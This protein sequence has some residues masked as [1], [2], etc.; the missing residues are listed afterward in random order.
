MWGGAA[1]S[2]VIASAAAQLF[3]GNEMRIA[4]SFKKPVARPWAIFPILVLV[5]LSGFVGKGHAQ[6]TSIGKP[7]LFGSG[8]ACDASL[9]PWRSVWF[10]HFAGGLAAYRPG[11]P[12][13]SLVWQDQKLCFP[14]RRQCL[15][16][17]RAQH[18][19]FY[20]IHG[21]STCLRIR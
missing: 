17:Q 14:S 2:G 7:W 9:L 11:A 15:S 5:A 19:L 10:G 13:V 18:R 20:Q 3:Q 1:L 6:G 12:R 4:K 21:Y 8:I 16:W